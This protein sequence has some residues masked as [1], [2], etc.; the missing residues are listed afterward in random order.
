MNARARTKA[1]L[2]AV[3]LMLSIFSAPLAA[4]APPQSSLPP[5]LRDVGFDPQLNA[6]LPLDLP[7]RDEN[8]RDV[9]LSDYFGAKPVILALVYYQC[10]M[11]CNQVLAGLVSSLRILSFNPGREFNIVAVS[12]DPQ[13]TPAMAATKKHDTVERYRR[14]GTEPG[15]HFLTGDEASIAALTRA[16]GF[17]YAYDLKTNLYAHAS[18]ILV[19]T[20]Q[21]KI[22]RYFYGIEY[23]PRD[24]RLGLVEASANKIGTPVDHLLLFCYQ[25]DPGTGK[26]S[27]LVFRLVRLGGI[28]AVLSVVIS[29]LLFHRR[30]QRSGTLDR[31]G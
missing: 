14:A 22:S 31:T 9:R 19:L 24:L 6:A 27:A 13:E 5:L 18:G 26:Y 11:L 25:Y 10:P 16:A 12:F 30:E 29:I 17:R 23:A 2:C 7:F 3:F 21:G 28:L 8:G 20:P 15:W 4:Q 1:P